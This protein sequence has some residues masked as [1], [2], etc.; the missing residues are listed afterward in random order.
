DRTTRKGKAESAS[1][2]LDA[3][4]K[5]EK[6]VS[7]YM[8]SNLSFVVFEVE[9]KEERLFLESRLISTVSLCG[10]CKPSPG[11]LGNFS[12]K[13][14]IRESGLWLV[15]ELY[16]APLSDTELEELKVRLGRPDA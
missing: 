10:S 14:K 11:W 3:I 12:P 13:P 6:Q 1:F 16:K 2:D 9:K 15:N 4:I 7:D 5:I 8:R